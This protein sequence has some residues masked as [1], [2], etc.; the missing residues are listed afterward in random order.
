MGSYGHGTFCNFFL[1]LP[2][3]FCPQRI[4]WYV[5]N[6]SPKDLKPGNKYYY[7]VLLGDRILITSS[8]SRFGF[9]V[10]GEEGYFFFIWKKEAERSLY[11]IHF[12]ILDSG[13][14]SCSRSRT[15]HGWKHRIVVLHRYCLLE[16]DGRRSFLRDVVE[17][18][19][20]GTDHAKQA[21][22]PGLERNIL[23]RLS[24]CE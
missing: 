23:Y 15:C 19:Q 12:V 22:A 13:T 6:Q 2:D 16:I 3:E 17:S 18:D 1:S 21:S 5:S 24:D 8:P 20:V 10:V 14:G 4:R 11:S 9:V 7:S